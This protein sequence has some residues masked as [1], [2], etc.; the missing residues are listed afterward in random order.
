MSLVLI[1]GVPGF[2]VATQ[3]PGWLVILGPMI[4]EQ[5]EGQFLADC[6]PEHCTEREETNPL[7]FCERSLFACAGTLIWGQPSSLAHVQP[8]GGTLR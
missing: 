1:S 6:L 5:S 3:R 4:V 7:S 2:R 8:Y